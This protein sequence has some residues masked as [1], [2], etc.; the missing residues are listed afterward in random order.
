[1]GAALRLLQEVDDTY[2]RA[3]VGG[4][5]Y[6]TGW[7]ILASYGGAFAHHPALSWTM[8]AV[9][10]GFWIQRWLRR[11]PPFVD[12]AHALRW[13]RGHWILVIA[14]TAAW[15]ALMGWAVADPG[16]SSGRNAGLLATIGLATAFAHT[17][18]M[19]LG[20]AALGI[21]TLYLPAL[22]LLLPRE[23]LRADALVMLVYLAYVIVSLLRSHA[24]YQRRLD[25]DEQLR[26]QRDLFH[27]QSRMDALT[28]LAN[29]R[30]FADHMEQASTHARAT[31]E[32][33]S[34]LV[35]DLDHFKAIND[36]HGHS[37]GDACLVAFAHRLA[38]EFD[39]KGALAAR[40][41]GEEF[42]V[43]LEGQGEAEAMARAEAFRLGCLQRPID[44]GG[45]IPPIAV[46]IGVSSYDAVRHG[47][48]DGLFRAADRAVYRAKAAGRNRVCS[49]ETRAA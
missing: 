46:S 1:M 14:T 3:L 49:D 8:L 20:F 5:F 35:L 39:G 19:R 4:P 12:D 38:A 16:F 48:G 10:V 30:H 33:L 28:E 15:G 24:E 32:P 22:V 34:L 45:T 2:R 29:R 7:V 18:S 37:A 25:L 36:T 47:E 23:D 40:L 6:A 44:L 42:G 13:L 9:F 17:F 41:G 11:P 27:R 31:G 21:A 43:L 26:D